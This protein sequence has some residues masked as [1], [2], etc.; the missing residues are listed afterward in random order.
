[1]QPAMTASEFSDNI[2]DAISVAR[3]SG[4]SDDAIITSLTTIIASMS[5][6]VEGRPYK[7]LAARPAIWGPTQFPGSGWPQS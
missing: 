4:V 3:A 1:M 7:R 5:Y 2:V 6:L